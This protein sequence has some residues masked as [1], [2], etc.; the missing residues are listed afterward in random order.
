MSRTIDIVVI[1]AGHAG[2]EA[3]LAAT[4]LLAHR[5]PAAS[6][7]SPRVVL[8]TQREDAVARMSC[9]PAL[10]GLGK[11]HLVREVDALGG[12]MGEVGDATGIHFR[13]LNTRKGAAVRGT[14][15]QSDMAAYSAAMRQ[16]VRAQPGLELASGEVVDLIVRGG[17][18]CGLE[19][20]D[21]TTL[22]A[23]AVVLTTGTFLGGQLH[24]GSRQTPGGRVGE[25]AATRLSAALRAL[26]LPLARLKTGTPCRLDRRSIDFSRLEAQPGDTPPPRLS[27]WS[28]WPDGRPPLRQVP[29]HITYTN[30][31]THDVIRANLERSAIYAGAISSRGP[32][33]CPSIEDKIVRFADRERHQ[34]F[35]EPEGLDS[36]LVYPNGISTSLPEDA[37][38]ALVRSIAGFEQA[39]IVR[40]GYAVEYDYVDPT[41]LRTS[42][43][44]RDLE[45]L[46]LAGQINGT[47]GYEEAAAQGLLAGVNAAQALCDGEPLLLRRDQA[48]TGVLVD[49]LVTRGVGAEPYRMFTSRAEYRLLLREDN[50]T[51]RLTPLARELGL[52]D[53]SR[54]Q[55]FCEQQEAEAKLAATLVETCVPRQPDA[56]DAELVATGNGKARPGQTLAELLRRPEVDLALLMRTGLLPEVD[57]MVG[58]PVE[59]ATKYAPYI[60]RQ[61]EEAA[62]LARLDDQRLPTALDYGAISGL[63]N[64]VREKLARQRPQSLG[65]AGRI[66]GMTPA[67]LALLAVNLR[68]VKVQAE[69]AKPG[70]AERGMGSKRGRTG[71][72][73]GGS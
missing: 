1:G 37:Q 10:G 12:A 58:E 68:V 70:G 47:T 24:V 23:K 63:S 32:R 11:G 28:R 41:N 20:A 73:M 16:R 25:P 61:R 69:T 2:V 60:E 66:P 15:V 39:R 27:A 36:E 40:F 33:Y 8:L 3:A 72:V 51:A 43:E 71:G 31:R 29:C 48:Y 52:I 9:N 54:W 21:G 64:E 42:L 44:L 18:L 14:R 55:R 30:P 65:Q 57:A 53:E 34:V 67:A 49:D 22:E 38:E 62:K 17:R 46:Y 26:G 19:L 50:A 4:R 13:R 7:T 56:L 6:G 35:V 59:I 45:G 5:S